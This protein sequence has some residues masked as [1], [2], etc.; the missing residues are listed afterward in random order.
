MV[1]PEGVAVGTISEAAA[2]GSN[3]HRTRRRTARRGEPHPC[4]RTHPATVETA[5][6][7]VIAMRRLLEAMERLR[8]KWQRARSTWN[9]V[10]QGELSPEA[11]DLRFPAGLSRACRRQA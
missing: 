5:L 11:D 9:T 7:E 4:N 8:A 3:I 6:R 2:N 1:M 10:P